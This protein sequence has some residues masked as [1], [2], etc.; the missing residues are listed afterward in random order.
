MWPVTAS[1][2][3][4]QVP[5]SCSLSACVQVKDVFR[6]GCKEE[7]DNGGLG[8][9]SH[10]SEK[11]LLSDEIDSDQDETQPDNTQ[12]TGNK[13][14]RRGVPLNQQVCRGS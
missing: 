5:R 11:E 12:W 14:S 13:Q 2:L 3:A 1:Q 6:H 9:H 4:T 7:D 8:H 10:T